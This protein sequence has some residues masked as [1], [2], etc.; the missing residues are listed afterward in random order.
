MKK[1]YE[2]LQENLSYIFKVPF[3]KNTSGGLLL[4][5]I[6]QQHPWT[7]V[8]VFFEDPRL[9][10]LR[11]I[12][13]QSSRFLWKTEK[14]INPFL[15]LMWFDFARTKDDMIISSWILCREICNIFHLSSCNVLQISV[16]RFVEFLSSGSW[17]KY[18][19]T[20]LSK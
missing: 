12:I 3:P 4:H 2:N 17:W 18:S 6:L 11:W 10:G 20:P 1:C 9:H 19:K 14:L 15:P 5:I 16:E 7:C 8:L 13:N